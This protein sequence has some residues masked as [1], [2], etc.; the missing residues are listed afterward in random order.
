MIS[1]KRLIQLIEVII[2]AASILCFF[3]LLKSP[4]TTPQYVGAF[5]VIFAEIVFFGGLT[6]AGNLSKDTEKVLFHSGTT[7]ILTIYLIVACATSLIYMFTVEEGIRGLLIIQ[8]LLFAFLIVLFLV[9]TRAAHSVYK[10]NEDTLQAVSATEKFINQLDTLREAYGYDE[11]IQPLIDA[12]K[13]GDNSISADADR[14]I[15]ASISQLDRTLSDGNQKKAAV[16]SS[17]ENID[18]AIEKRKRQVKELKAG[19]I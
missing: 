7:V 6:A 11:S 10:K 17:I 9:I 3:L 15:E 4:I 13:Y 19:R 18:F 12:L 5:F 16:K 1:R 8:I 14:E 2:V